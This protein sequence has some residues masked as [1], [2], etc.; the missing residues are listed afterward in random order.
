MGFSK[1]L[2]GWLFTTDVM[3]SE[4][5]SLNRDTYPPLFLRPFPDLGY[6][7]HCIYYHCINLESVCL[8]HVHLWGKYFFYPQNL[9]QATPNHKDQKWHIP[10]AWLNLNYLLSHCSPFLVSQNNPVTSTL[11]PSSKLCFQRHCLRLALHF[12]NWILSGNPALSYQAPISS[13]T[14]ILCCLLFFRLTFLPLSC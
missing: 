7:F 3:S 6:F 14:T 2:P 9:E 12:S 13:R 1:L 11:Y 8:I 5:T 4:E 10:K